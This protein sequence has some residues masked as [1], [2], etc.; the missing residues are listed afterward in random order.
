MARSK[1]KVRIVPLGGLGEIGKNMTVIEIGRDAI[2][3]DAGI[4]FPAND[5][6][7]V[8]Y[9]IPDFRYLLE[10]ND[11]R[12]HGIV[13][14]HGH[15]DHIGAVA[16][17]I[18]AFPNLPMYATPLT[19]GLVE[20]KLRDAGL[21]QNA[22]LNVFKSGDV[23]K[24]GP[25]TLESFHMTHSIPDC[26]G[27]AIHTP[28]GLIVF[29]GDYKF[30]N[31]PID[32][33]RP[34]YAKLAE[35]SGR[36]VVMLMGDST[37]ADKPG[38]TPSEVVIE[39]GFDRV[40]RRATGRIFVATFASLI[41]RVQ[42]VANA[43]KQH[44]RKLAIA[45]YSMTRNV[46]MARK[47]GILDIPDDMLVDLGKISS[48]PPHE[49]VIMATGSQ[50][51]P[52]AVMARMA[53]GKHRLLDVQKGDTIILSS[54]PIPGNEEMV[55][56]NI[57]RLLQRGADVIYDPLEDVHVSGHG[58]REE[59]RLMINLVRPKNVMPCHG[60]LR[61]LH[62]HGKL[63]VETGVPPENVFVVENGQVVEIDK[64]GVRLAERVP[65]GYV[66]VDGSGVGDIGRIVIRDR[67][68]L[69]R[70]GFLLVAVN[71]SRETNQIIG[72]PEII[73]R[74]FVYLRDSDE[75]LEQVKYTIEDVINNTNSSNGRRREKLQDSLSRLL[76]NETKRR[77]M[78]FSVLNE[79]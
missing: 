74:G 47:L 13:F 32:G 46:E 19:A 63:A 4:M 7:G 58:R 34:D 59:M 20:V 6:H 15:E 9:I 25:F 52:S 28:Y 26:A 11:L 18:E 40:F 73:S 45:G 65:G 62:L 10:R 41:S 57:N 5:M 14:T 49:L 67:E 23:L 38:W 33:K 70:D 24:V 60:E 50:G 30:D 22:K 76:Y 37:N 75:L 27:F 48:I 31:T 78:V 36:G 53:Y 68:I 35:F 39:A 77:P 43:A 51:E 1:P 21:M 42:L 72:Q 17:V 2:I 79:I 56:R 29:T 66:F 16:H 64:Y 61:H 71:V 44:N 55:S 12:L 69:A 54:H 3:I 8:D